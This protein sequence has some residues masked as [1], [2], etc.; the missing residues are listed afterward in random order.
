MIAIYNRAASDLDLQALTEARGSLAHNVATV[1]LPVAALV[2]ALI[3]MIWRSYLAAAVVAGSL[4]VASLRS[5]ISFFRRVRRR[6]LLKADNSA[7]EV[8][9]ASAHRVVDIEALGDN[10][11]ALCFFVGDGKALLLVGQWLLNYDSFPAESF[12]IHRWTDSKECIRIE[13]TGPHI[14]A[15]HSHVRLRPSHR[16]RELE[17]IDANPETL[18]EDLDRALDKRAIRRLL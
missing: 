14:E 1:S 17:L 9:E 2:F 3:Y 6:R 13:A 8:L 12:R 5:N 4:F 16:F 18:Q 10:S 15:E 11:P 7:V